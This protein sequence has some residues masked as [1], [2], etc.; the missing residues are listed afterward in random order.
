MWQLQKCYWKK[1]VD[2]GPDQLKRY[3][4]QWQNAKKHRKRL[5]RNKRSIAEIFSWSWKEYYEKIITAANELKHSH[6]DDA[7]NLL[8]QARR[9]FRSGAS[10][11]KFDDDT[12]RGIAGSHPTSIMS[13]K[14]VDIEVGWFGFT[15]PAGDFT[16]AIYENNPYLSDALD[17]IPNEGKVTRSDYLNYI[18]GYKKALSGKRQGLGVSTRLPT[19]K[20]PDIFTTWNRG[21]GQFLK[22]ELQ[23]KS[24]L[25]SSDYERYWDEVIAPISESDWCDSSPPS[26]RDKLE[27]DIWQ[28]RVAMLD[29]LCQERD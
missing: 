13:G 7:R 16:H 27:F 3:K 25:R 14:Y 23:L 18:D 22:K 26:K 19:I 11:L 6:I 5:Q 17:N 9:D 24:A 29:V 21:N 4:E 8:K 28:N 20:R 1:A 10:F 2:I 12:R 15:Y